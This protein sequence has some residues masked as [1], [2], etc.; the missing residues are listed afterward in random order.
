ML[1]C[2]VQNLVTYLMLSDALLD[3]EA[4]CWE[5]IFLRAAEAQLIGWTFVGKPGIAGDNKFPNFYSW[6]II[7][8]QEQ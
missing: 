8:Q 6:S 4:T 3:L 5:S 1:L 2:M 7:K